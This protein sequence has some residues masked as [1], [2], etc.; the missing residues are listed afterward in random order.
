MV[1]RDR[2]LIQLCFSVSTLN[3]LAPRELTD[4]VDT[5]RNHFHFSDSRERDLSIELDP[6]FVSPADVAELAA[7]GFNRAS[8]GVQDFDP[9]VQAAVNRIQSVEEIGRAHV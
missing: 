9:A 6:R 3:C 1:Y 8:L 2:E 7:I 4:V 5:L